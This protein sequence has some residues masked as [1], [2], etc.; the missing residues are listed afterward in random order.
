MG[1]Y[2]EIKNKVKTNGVTFD[3]QIDD[4]YISSFINDYNSYAQRAKTDYQKSTY[5]TSQKMSDDYHKQWMDL[6]D[7]A[8]Y[9][10]AYLNANA[11]SIDKNRYNQL[12]STLDGIYKDSSAISKSFYDKNSQYRKFKTEE[13]YT[14]NSIG[15]LNPDS[16]T[17]N[18]N[19]SERQKFYN[20]NKQK[21][22]S[23]Q[24]QI[25]DLQKQRASFG[26]VWLWET[27]ERKSDKQLK[28]S[29]K[30]LQDKIKAI[31]TEN[32]Q[33]ERTQGVLDRY[34]GFSQNTD[35][36]AKSA[37][38][39]HQNPTKEDFDK[40][41]AMINGGVRYDEKGV[42]YD[43]F[44]N[45][46][47]EKY[48]KNT[49][50]EPA[51]KDKL[52]L[53]LSSS[54]K[55][56]QEAYASGSGT[57]T[58]SVYEKILKD[59][60][61][62][63]W[64]E[65]TDDEV[66][67]YY[68]LLN[69]EGQKSAEKYLTEMQ[70]ELNRRQ[71]LK[72]TQNIQNK[73]DNG[74]ILEKIALNAA[75]VPASVFGGSVAF[76]EDALNTLRGRDINP[77]SA[78][79]SLSN[80]SQ[81]V[82]SSTAQN[83]NDLTDNKEFLGVNLGD[84]YQS[85]MSAGDSAMGAGLG[86]NAYGALMGMNAASSK[87]K[88][89]YES[90]ASKGQIAIGGILAGAA[91]GV[92]E[93]V[94][95]ESLVNLK[96]SK[97]I[98]QVILNTL[99][100]GGIEA[101]EEMATEVANTLTD[102]LVRGSQS[103]FNKYVQE[104]INQ[105]KTE[106]SAQA[107]ALL[108][109]GKNVWKSGVGGFISGALLGGT[110]SGT[111]YSL[112][113]A[114]NLIKDPYIGRQI[115][116][117][118]NV[119][120]LTEYASWIDKNSKA[121]K[122]AQKVYG[123]NQTLQAEPVQ[124][125][126]T[127]ESEDIP[128]QGRV[129][130]RLSAMGEQGNVDVLSSAV[131]K[132]VSGETLSRPEQKAIGASK[133][134]KTILGE[135]KSARRASSDRNV[136]RM[137]RGVT[138]AYQA[139]IYDEA[140]GNIS[141]RLTELGESE[142]V[143][144]LSKAVKK[145]VYGENL[146]RKEATAL[147]NSK[148][149]QRVVEEFK[150]VITPSEGEFTNSWLTDT[151]TV[152]DYNRISKLTKG[153]ASPR[154]TVKSTGDSVKIEG[155]KS[156]DDNGNVTLKLDNGETVQADEVDF[157]T[158]TTENLY[159]IGSKYGALGV[160]TFVN[161]YNGEDV[162]RYAPAFDSFYKFGV[163]DPDGK[164]WES[165]KNTDFAEWLNPAQAK[166]AYELGRAYA[167]NKSQTAQAEINT[168]RTTN[169]AKNK[170]SQIGSQRAREGVDK[171]KINTENLSPKQ[172]A[173][174]DVLEKISAATNGELKF[175]LFE[176]S[177]DDKGRRLGANGYYDPGTNTIHLDIEAGID[178]AFRQGELDRAMLRTAS[179]ELT[180]FIEKW[181]PEQ[182]RNLRNFVYET[183]NR[184]DPDT[185]RRLIAAQR[186][187][188]EKAGHKLSYDE[189]SREVVADACEMLLRDSNAV[190]RLVNENLTLAQKIRDWVSDFVN[191]IKKAF[192]GV[193]ART[194]EARI[195]EENIRQWSDIQALWDNALENAL[196][197]STEYGAQGENV[198]ETDNIM[199]Y[200]RRKSYYDEYTSLV[201]R[202]ANSADRKEGD[203]KIFRAK[204]GEYKLLS[205]NGF[206]G[207]VELA[208]GSFKEMRDFDEQTFYESEKDFDWY[209]E[210]RRRE[211]RRYNGSDELYEN[212]RDDEFVD[213][214]TGREL[215]TVNIRTGNEIGSS[216]DKGQSVKFSNRQ[217][218]DAVESGD[219]ET[220]QRMVDE[221][222]EGA[223]PDSIIRDENGKLLTVY[224]GS[225]GKFTVFSHNKMNVNGNAHGRGFYF[226]EEKN[227]AEG[228]Q[229]DGGQLLKGYLNI[230]KPMSEEKVTIKKSDLVK[231]I[232]AT[233]EQEAR[234][235]VADGSYDS[236]N[237]AL[238]DTWVSNY[239]Y[240]YG[241]NLNQAYKEVADIIYSNDNDID[242]LAEISNV[243]GADIALKKAHEVLGY[244]GVIYT[245]DRGT[246]EY[247]ALISNQFKSAE[248]VTY[249]D[250]GNVILLT[251]RFDES[252][253]DIRYSRRDYSYDSLISK[254]DMKITVV[255]DTVKY[256]PSKET[257]KNII[258]TAINNAASVGYTNENG[259]AVVRVKDIDT[260]V[261][262]S[263][264]S[265]AHG[266]DRRLE[267]TAPV[268][269][270]I[271]EI[272]KN[273]IE[274]N[275]LNS[276]EQ[277]AKSSYILVGSAQGVN[278][279]LFIVRSVVNRYANEV[280]SVDVL[281][282]VST[283]KESAGIRP[284]V[285][286][287]SA[288]PTDSTI[289]IS[290]LLD[291]VN[292]YFS[293]ILPE[294]VLKH[295]GHTRRPDGKLGENVLF[296]L[297]GEQVSSNTLAKQLKRDY[298]TEVSATDIKNF[299]DL[300]AEEQNKILSNQDYEDLWGK[301][302]EFS[303]GILRKSK[304]L[305]IENQV[306]ADQL[307]ELKDYFRG[308]KFKLTPDVK[309][310]VE[311]Q[312][313]DYKTFKDM[314]F[315]K[316][317]YFSESSPYSLDSY[318]GEICRTFPEIFDEETIPND[319]PA[320]I[321]EAFESFSVTE[322]LSE[323]SEYFEE[324]A[325]DIADRIISSLPVPERAE[326]HNVNL[327]TD[328]NLTDRELLANALLTAAKNETEKDYLSRYKKQI[329]E[330][331]EKNRQVAKI[332]KQIHDISF[333]KGSD[334][335]QLVA[336]KNRA[337][338]LESQIQRADK[339][340]LS[341]EATKA[342]K[343]VVEREKKQA[344]KKAKEQGNNKLQDYR[345][346]QKASAIRKGI[347][348]IKMDLAHRIL[349][350]TDGKY[351][352]AYLVKSMIDVCN[353]ID[354]DTGRTAPDG[355]KTKAQQKRDDLKHSLDI[356]R[357]DYDS[358]KTL[359][360][361]NYS[362]E[363]DEAI[364]QELTQLAKA[365]GNS[366]VN[367]M[368]YPQL[369]QVYNTLKTI[370]GTLRDANYQ[371]G[372][373]EK[374]ANAKLGEEIVREQG[375]ISRK[376]GFKALTQ[377]YGDAMAWNTI[378]PMRAVLRMCGYNKDSQLYSLMKQLNEGQRKKDRF[379]MESHKMFEPLIEGKENKKKYY[380]AIEKAVDFGI[381]DIDGNPV[382][383]SKM[384]AMQL[385]MSWE[386]E[387]ASNG[388]LSHLYQNGAKI[389]NHKLLM[390]GKVSEAVAANNAQHIKV[391]NDVIVKLAEKFDEWD[392]KYMETA[393]EF[394]D[395]KSKF[396]LNETS[397]VVSHRDVA[398]SVKYIP[399][400][401]DGDYVYK[402]EISDTNQATVRPTLTSMG[403]LK[404]TVRNAGQPLVMTSLNHV[405][406]TQIENVARYYGLAIPVRNFNKVWNYMNNN[407][408]SVRASVTKNWGEKGKKLVDDMIR[409]LQ[410][411]RV[412]ERSKL[413]DTANSAFVRSVLNSNISVTIKQ[414]SALPSAFAVLNQRL[415]P[416]YVYAQFAKVCVPKVYNRV[417]SEIDEH[418]AAHWVR[419]QGLSSQE[420]GDIAKSMGLLKRIDNKLPAALN[421]TK[422]IQGMDCL[423]TASFWD[424]CK[425]DIEK[426]GK[427]QK[428]SEEYWNAVT[429]L[430]NRVIEDTQAVYDT[431]HR[432]EVLKTTNALTRQLFMFRSES[433]QHSGIVFEK[434]GNFAVNKDKESGKEFAKACYSQFASA[435]SFASLTVVAAA[436]LHKMNP[437]RDDDEELTPESI[438]AEFL[439]D[440][441]NVLAD[442]I[443]PVGGTQ[444]QEFIYGKIS[445]NSFNA[446]MLDVPAISIFN[447]FYKSLNNLWNVVNAEEK[448]ETKIGKAVENLIYKF[449][450]LF[451]F[452]AQNA[453]NI[454][455]AFWLHIEDAVNGEFGS[456]E[457][458]VER[459]N[460]VNYHRATEA[461]VD[462]KIEK[463]DK[464]WKE[465]SNGIALEE[466]EKK[467]DELDET[468][469]L[470]IK[471]KFN[472]GVISEL[473]K[474]YL[475][476]EV[477]KGLVQKLLKEYLGVSDANDANLTP[478]YWVAELEEPE[479]EEE[480]TEPDYLKRVKKKLKLLYSQKK[481]TRPEVEKI[482]VQYDD[483]TVDEIYWL[484][485]EWDF[486]NE[487]P[488]TTEE[489]GKYDDLVNA[490]EN[491]QDI[492]NVARGYLDNH[493]VEKDD[494][495]RTLTAKF[496]DKYIE[497]YNTDK[498]EAANL[499][500]YLLQ[501]YTAV[502]YEWN[503]KSK[504]ID[505]WLEE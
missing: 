124:A 319:Q 111:E 222:A 120:P 296:S 300:V 283:K 143:E 309:R 9:I 293:D 416:G 483:L 392:K 428:D 298:S 208:T 46:V 476:D 269:L 322:G 256:K 240:T 442:L 353:A 393:H 33:Y 297:R 41:N 17:N 429:E 445:G 147:D 359:H 427:Y 350:P 291:Y 254:P 25:D 362:S 471:E 325:Q 226:T 465:F 59:G 372:I 153:V 75:S 321:L 62:G 97:K 61:L 42:G 421:P 185:V 207:Y 192:E 388:K 491:N 363:Y 121:Y 301:V 19:A 180:H 258:D 494:I 404:D 105:G 479:E 397:R 341:F 195:L 452:P 206:G 228:Y 82:R 246:H 431:L 12:M 339:R 402:A 351:V 313:G 150:S 446:D 480:P 375:A 379:V 37:N 497:L 193:T 475:N 320:A 323:N 10:R 245:N 1:R 108:D 316:K 129:V 424:M 141:S 209:A 3:K 264:K 306:K 66:S 389:P 469:K 154:V 190:E 470:L 225:P 101:S 70:T 24:K 307:Q 23:Y 423:V 229:K 171:S 450:G 217:Y 411:D 267:L 329:D 38:R 349:K 311:Y 139:R 183:L 279:E 365:V 461:L 35:F 2:Q 56:I 356:L 472:N 151:D 113:S 13:D 268:I 288:L 176:S 499:K 211:Q 182:Y 174:I 214:Q 332:R 31:E 11:N 122:L 96:D 330:L 364:S 292:K 327:R 463:Y 99:K 384:T 495:S 5:S 210:E 201:M 230:T 331:N 234:N 505:K 382:L 80:F 414:L 194:V 247:V 457:A 72:Q 26:G 396:A 177:V 68:Y 271:G 148:N 170:T 383:M 354:T 205:A 117:F 63:G 212:R 43:V 496:K 360:D 163:A 252:K 458:G 100:Q 286:D 361:P 413:L 347:A 83:L 401:V 134:A 358:L 282:A 132:S 223:M 219:M 104:Y 444:L 160:E 376:K 133:A 503:K 186:I 460:T 289:S 387:M 259:N 451:G 305:D 369:E 314:M 432:P 352:P 161:K 21:I 81:D 164:L 233:C 118:D 501:A 270:N 391:D 455:K 235:L 381:T 158:S 49:L 490:I 7:R 22:T 220:A 52:G 123:V 169:Q 403:M 468:Q 149:A 168:K 166:A 345:Q 112:R 60:D 398:H 422:W 178:D 317:I 102:A 55:Q 281:Y 115:K 138:E 74:T 77:Y 312:Y 425:K 157:E 493:G 87:A 337:D 71:N 30:D 73:L 466:Y 478:D 248:P 441:T 333:T 263:K 440:L 456:F 498:S 412:S 370:R 257:R 110:A 502:G 90:G 299:I 179:H 47:D 284:E 18:S 50:V 36:S 54:D 273:A 447:D 487:N 338:I 79:H 116:T 159:S 405:L 371:I 407:T 106:S 69:T 48:Y 335:S 459:S 175:S 250:N 238:P 135:F 243:V 266:L 265:V 453:A 76:A 409:D 78:A 294:E 482:L 131:T 84:V 504:D 15:W 474:I 500:N 231:F 16:G 454:L 14:K 94:S 103:D 344:M 98:S 435:L 196:R 156:V 136:G 95:I 173:S 239:V 486:E 417:I 443:F 40:Y 278:G 433:L 140:E 485:E 91:E 227:M 462:D 146:T 184:N 32:R 467:Y 93:K 89:L 438:T 6:N 399:F 20:T 191:K 44:G 280:T 489:Y 200:S 242:I 218:L 449:A 343:D 419:R 290:N 39:N 285:T 272:L 261:I 137:Y 152:K 197:S 58:E 366:R 357:S 189:A 430:Y 336:L 340:L 418:T 394:F 328:T 262:I 181:S 473:K 410:A 204:S 448:D 348:D 400:T 303:K 142:N 439:N 415:V 390:S 28:N 378:S 85:V 167:Q 237:D 88:E 484:L 127:S 145:T 199:E 477:D 304:Q 355:S 202:W 255:D 346:K 251:E 215:S 287:D 326:N 216:G 224:H 4:K 464:V 377:K 374:I 232:K 342:L 203:T 86:G 308:K 241:M 198:V 249:D 318:W 27:D 34:Y 57:G 385:A 434:Y 64:S 144:M 213:G 126:E 253:E 130:A 334:R 408:V 260:D 65:L 437:Y 188:A 155:V 395:I 436:L 45:V 165:A 67:T 8:G 406:D 172:K 236:V 276:R 380:N 275:E 488:D 53:F 125:Q 244:D 324:M 310:E 51:V 114:E 92:F 386:R 315:G 107:L 221:A 492:Y 187:N 162:N 481:I 128:L 277:S 29:I 368:T 367:E 274:I 295:Y 373:N 119:E 420:L 426:T 109:V 302:V